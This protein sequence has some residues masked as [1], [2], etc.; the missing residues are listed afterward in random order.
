MEHQKRQDGMRRSASDRKAVKLS[1]NN[2][3]NGAREETDREKE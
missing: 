2:A 3:L 1:I